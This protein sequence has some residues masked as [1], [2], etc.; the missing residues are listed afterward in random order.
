M[1]K[2]LAWNTFKNTGNINTFMEL[3]KF[4]NMEQSLNVAQSVSINDIVNE[5]QTLNSVGNMDIN[6]SVN[7][8]EG[9]DF[10]NNVNDSE[11]L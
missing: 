1:I 8:S 7:A 3:M 2:Q 6:C 4:K 10:N 5:E 9:T 11:I